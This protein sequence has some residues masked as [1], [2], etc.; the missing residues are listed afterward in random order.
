MILEPKP[1]KFGG[2][3]GATERETNLYRKGVIWSAPGPGCC[4]VRYSQTDA[5]YYIMSHARKQLLCARNRI[6]HSAFSR[7]IK[8]ILFIQS[9][10]TV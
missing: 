5:N 3:P 10:L 6:A 1:N 4:Q 9:S 2:F 7:W 8:S